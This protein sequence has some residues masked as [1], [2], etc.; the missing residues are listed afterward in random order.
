V[1][2]TKQQNFSIGADQPRTPAAA[3]NRRTT[4]AAAEMSAACNFSKQAD[5]S[6]HV[7]LAIFLSQF[8][9]LSGFDIRLYNQISKAD[10]TVSAL[11]QQI[12]W[13]TFFSTRRSE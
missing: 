4:V 8:Y 1:E 2:G 7:C 5:H 12:V 9:F 13:C 3:G 6:L 11:K 10:D